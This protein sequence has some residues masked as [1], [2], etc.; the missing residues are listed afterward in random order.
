MI[1][2]TFRSVLQYLR[3][4]KAWA[5]LEHG[6]TILSSLSLF[7][8]ILATEHLFDL[9]TETG[10]GGTS[11]SQVGIALAI[12]TV[13]TISQ[14]V[15]RGTDKYVRGY[16]SYRNVGLFMSELML[17]LSRLPAKHFENPSFL[18][19]IDRTKRCIEYESL[20]Y[21]SSDCLRFY[22]YYGVFF[23]SIS[24]YFFRLSPLLPLIIF[25]SF[26]PAILGQLAQVKVFTR[27]EDENA[28]L[29]RQNTYYKKAISGQRYFK[30][31]RTLGA[32]GFFRKLFTDSLLLLT[33]KTWEVEKKA[34]LIRLIL[35]LMS[36]IGFALSTLLL[37]NS[38]M[39][40]DISIGSFVAVFG[41]LSS[42]FSMAEEFVSV[43]MGQASETLGQI[44]SYYRLL[45]MEEV[46]GEEAEIDF[47]KGIL[48]KD[49]SFAYPESEHR[50][51]ENV[52]LTISEGE[53][54]AIVGENGAGKTTLVRLLIGLYS[55]GQGSVE[56]GGLNTSL[57]H[58]TSI[59]R[60]ISGVFQNF[61]RYKMT[62]GENV[63]ISN[64]KESQDHDHIMHVLEDCNFTDK[65]V[66]LDTMLSTEF[67][68]VDL[69]GGQWQRIAI[70]RGLY[71]PHSLI[72]LDE[73]TAAIDPIEEERIYKQFRELSKDKITILVT[74][75]LASAK[76]AH[77]IVVMDK[78]EIID[79]GSHDELLE[80]KGKYKTMWEAQ[81]TWYLNREN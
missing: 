57:I 61:I 72:V 10:K 8:G 68:G 63:A 35:S 65:S 78:G 6:I 11:H 60:G 29:H 33:K 30:E 81:S 14:Q 46:G 43:Y 2:L 49:I 4:S 36:F 52:S 38:T 79:I 28:P 67:D 31:T 23:I 41:A 42:I 44:E 51:V 74:H 53:T 54:I 16:V 32:F 9:I 22:T 80:R 70:A 47:S 66:E 17:K 50:A 26:I 59:Y 5:V 21:F 18:D 71:R 69:S 37:F 1:Y 64:T 39:S 58:P 40:G 7:L 15:L 20:G 77:R 13:I 62:L 25:L 19:S 12:V 3:T 27:L 45:D 55:P 48:A 73:P 56:I 34:A 75:R 24:F 76:F